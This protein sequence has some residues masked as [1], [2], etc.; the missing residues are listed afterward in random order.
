MPNFLESLRMLSVLA[1]KQQQGNVPSLNS[2]PINPPM[3]GSMQQQQEQPY[4][5]Q[6][7]FGE[8]YKPSNVASTR[9]DSLI[10]QYPQFQKPN[11]LM[12]IG[13][14]L[15]ALGENGQETANNILYG[16]YSQHLGQWKTQLD[17]A[18]K[19]ADLENEANLNL[20]NLANQQVQREI[21]ERDLS[22]KETADQARAD[23]ANKN[24][25][26]TRMRAEA[27][28]KR[29]D[30]IEFKTKNPHYVF[31]TREDGRIMG[32]NPLVPNQTIDTG[33]NSGDLSDM[34]KAALQ[35]E[36]R[37]QA[38]NTQGAIRDK[39]IERQGELTS[40]QISQRADETRQTNAARPPTG[41]TANRDL[42]PTQQRVQMNNIYQQMKLEDPELA[43]QVAVDEVGQFRH[44]SSDPAIRKRITD[45]FTTHKT[46]GVNTP[47]VNK[48][49]IGGNSSND[50]VVVQDAKGGKFSIPATQLDAFLKSEQGKGFKKVQ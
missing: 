14:S 45:Y 22:R 48:T 35:L 10:N 11:A 25:D 24:A 39:Q 2:L 31:K 19:S 49:P 9:L 47:Q 20:R 28:Q 17:P 42:L 37:L 5:V 12:R 34:D 3:L 23:T 33:V 32:I 7:R 8:I 4:N 40:S 36:G 41:S 50:R 29:T 44:K 1:P 16:P 13:A 30:L 46:K 26:S 27:Y 38:I 18:L 15:A 6:Q 43:A 21:S